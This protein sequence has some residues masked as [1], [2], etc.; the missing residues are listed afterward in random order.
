MTT[1]TVKQ[2]PAQGFLQRYTI[3]NRFLLE[4]DADEGIPG[5]RNAEDESGLSVLVKNWPRTKQVED[6][7]LREI[8]LNEV[9]EL[10]RLAAYPGAADCIVE[11]RDS[12]FDL[13]GFYL[14]LDAGQRSP[15]ASVLERA[16]TL[17]WLKNP[18]LERDRALL[19]SNLARIA[20]GLDL[21]HSQG[22]L[23][24]KLDLWSVLTA[25][26]D[27][28]DFLLTGFE[29]SMRL[30][31]GVAD[32]S[33]PRSSNSS[34][35]RH[36]SFLR[37]WQQF[38]FLAARL[39]ALDEGKLYD[40]AVAPQDA[41]PNHTREE[42]VLLRELAGVTRVARIDGTAVIERIES[43][44]RALQLRE[45]RRDS[46]LTL[47]VSLGDMSRLSREIREA[48]ERHIEMSDL[49]AQLAFVQNDLG[50]DAVAMTVRDSRQQDSFS[51]VLRGRR[52]SY[53]VS[54]Y[55]H[56]PN[57]VPSNWA[58]AF[59]NH[60]R[61]STTAFQRVL[62]QLALEPDRLHVL[63]TE[64]MRTNYARL[65]TKGGSWAQLRD[66]LRP[67]AVSQ[68]ALDQHL[69]AFLLNQVLECLFAAAEEFPVEIVGQ[70]ANARNLHPAKHHLFLRARVDSEREELSKIVGH[71]DAPAIRL[72]RALLEE[73][74]NAEAGWMLT[75]DPLV[76]ETIHENT[77]WQFA[78]S[79]R[80]AT[81][82]Q[83][84]YFAGDEPAPNI[85]SPFLV[86]ADSPRN[87]LQLRRRLDALATL[88]EH[89]ELS[90]MLFDPRA[91]L[92][93]THD[94]VRDDE[95]LK[96]LDSD[97][98]AAIK[99]LIAILPVFLLQGPPGV[100]KTRLLTELVKRRFQSERSTRMLL[101]AQSHHAVDHLLDEVG[102]AIAPDSRPKPLMVR[103]RSRDSR[104]IAG[105]YELSRQTQDLIDSVVGSSLFAK[106][107]PRLRE[108]LNLLGTTQSR[109]RNRASGST[110]LTSSV[111][112]RRPLEAL[113]LRS[114]NL[115]F[116][117]SNAAEL[118]RLLEERSQFDWS[119][120]EEAA[121]AT[122]NELISSLLLSYR[123]LLIG[124]HKQ[125]PPYGSDRM[126]S[127]LA[128]PAD[129]RKAL[130]MADQLMRRSLRDASVNE[131]VVELG[132]DDSDDAA[133]EI[134]S[135]TA[136]ADL[137]AL[138]HTKLFLFESLITEEFRR[139]ADGGRGPEIA[140]KLAFQHRMHPVLARIVS[141]AFYDGELETHAQ[142]A[143]R[144]GADPSPIISARPEILPDLPLIWIDTPYVQAT[145]GAKRSEYEPNY[146][147]P[148]E[149]AAVVQVLRQIKVASGQTR[150]P[151]LAVLSPYREQVRRISER[152]KNAD[153]P[154]RRHLQQF[155]IASHQGGYVSTVDS[156]QGNEADVVVVSLV[157]N[158]R[159]AYLWSALGFLADARRMNVLFSRAKWR[160]VV[161]GCL[162]FLDEVVR[163]QAHQDALQ[164]EF[165]TKLLEAVRA[166]GRTGEAGIVPLTRL[167]A[168]GR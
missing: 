119:V 157:R 130:A 19:W 14:V 113:V 57:R 10:H 125:L 70:P 152:I 56:G 129:V 23:H 122:G 67:P 101:T 162:D 153:M 45:A 76:P 139:Q 163:G 64:Q 59:C 75:E 25:G 71:R 30:V 150:Q 102:K 94:Q 47:V 164:I 124:D 147:N 6:A 49:D 134:E 165:L 12:G 116:A 93:N 13:E 106:A 108:R 155:K 32:R 91:R 37:D 148:D 39:L 60:A 31:S 40:A 160:L 100:G 107:S 92:L 137:C 120:V 53:H 79:L 154:L 151:S 62:S 133:G 117:T 65:R 127:L 168:A 161:V 72:R 5:L 85:R 80:D 126:Q 156:F 159:S 17:Q 29:W 9:R 36:T 78:G 4:P 48:S 55:S 109:D 54:D 74:A 86:D 88:R 131:L 3:Y 96:Q 104:R 16:E 66:R 2:K 136:S 42:T 132:N 118:E 167:R 34:L 121:K 99:S 1:L 63:S 51:M 46:K 145:S 50:R 141:E 112:T 144:F 69:K 90:R 135:D 114:A 26:T 18:R 44:A 143:Q 43:I 27:Q 97:K 81:G 146:H 15:L 38:A 166:A 83:F 123:R 8:W 98:Q 149:A 138:A 35:S 22:L 142:A 28:A 61:A 20:R 24:R 87:A 128:A 41:L 95:D 140:R 89:T 58:L 82:A 52:L 115:V 158:N 11:L 110:V 33:T 84:F 77:E 73:E 111:Y 103:C 105:P 68:S 21:L 7:D